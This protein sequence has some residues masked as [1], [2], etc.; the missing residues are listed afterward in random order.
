MNQ[1]IPSFD[2]FIVSCRDRDGFQYSSTF[3]VP[4]SESSTVVRRGW[5]EAIRLCGSISAVRSA[6]VSTIE[7]KTVGTL[8]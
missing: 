8:R 4:G 3:D 5:E 7:G 2:H 6:S 1:S